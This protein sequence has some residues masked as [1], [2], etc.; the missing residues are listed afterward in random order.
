MPLRRLAARF[1]AA[2]GPAGLAP[3]DLGLGEC[4]C[5]CCGAPARPERGALPLCPAC[6]SALARREGGFCPACG[7]LY[8]DE[9]RAPHRCAACLAAP[10]PFDRLAFWGRYAE[11]L[12]GLIMGYKYTDPRLGGG[13]GRSHLLGTLAHGA[14]QRLAGLDPALPLPDLAAPVPLHPHRLRMRGFNQ[15]LE[16]ARGLC[17]LSGLPLAA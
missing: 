1:L 13:L 10:P 5:Q 9:T 4:R 11:P 12:A 15:S 8:A 2:L 17:R 3:E 14:Y 16:L 6:R 7:E